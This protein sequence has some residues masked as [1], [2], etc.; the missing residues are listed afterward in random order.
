MNDYVRA[1]I[2]ILVIIL[3]F[4]FSYVSVEHLAEVRVIA[5]AEAVVTLQA[6]NDSLRTV[7]TNLSDSTEVAN[8]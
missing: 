4:G 2:I 5:D 8:E 6:E 1:G 7:I 3:I